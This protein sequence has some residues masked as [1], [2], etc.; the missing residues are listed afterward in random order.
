MRA[1]LRRS[2]RSPEETADCLVA[3]GERQARRSSSGEGPLT[4]GRRYPAASNY[5]EH[6]FIG[7][8]DLICGR[9]S[10]KP[11]FTGGNIW[12]ACWPE[13]RNKRGALLRRGS[14]NRRTTV[15]CGIQLRRARLRRSTRPD[16]WPNYGEACV[17]RRKPRIARWPEVSGKRGA[18][19]RRGPL[20][21][22]RR[23]P[24]ASNYGEPG[25]V[26]AHD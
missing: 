5:G 22:G 14:A 26:G 24:A 12:I 16:M 18:L 9:T 7:A 20:T 21:G 25:F 3:G 17:H 13:V 19:L 11:A 23:Y 1:E 6:V 4:G 2:L 10:A 15:S 8:Q